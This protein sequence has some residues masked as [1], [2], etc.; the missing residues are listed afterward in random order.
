MLQANV[1][2]R[3]YRSTFSIIDD[4]TSTEGLF[5]DMFSGETTEIQAIEQQ[6]N[7]HFKLPKH[8]PLCYKSFNR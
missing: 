5:S 7:F 3:K 4:M 2:I 1:I 8:H 6:N